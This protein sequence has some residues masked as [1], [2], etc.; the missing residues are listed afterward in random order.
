M[1]Q[2]LRS[3]STIA[4]YTASGS[5]T[6]SANGFSV[7]G[8]DGNEFNFT[9]DSY[10]TWLWKANGAGVSNTDGTITST[11]SVNTT[12]GFSIVTYTGTGANATV[13]HGLGVAPKMVIV[14]NRNVADRGWVVWH[15]GLSAASKVLILNSTAAEDT[16]TA[17]FQATIPTSSV[18]Y[19]GTDSWTNNSSDTYV[20]YAFA[21]V[22]GYSAFGSYTGNGSADGPMIFTG[23]RPRFILI[24]RS[25]DTDDWFMYDTAR[26][27]YNPMNFVLSPNSSAADTATTN[28]DDLSNGFKLR[29]TSGGTNG[30]GSTYIYM[31]FAENP[32]KYSNAR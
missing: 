2:T 7:S 17:A 1:V 13:G 32:F 9:G 14:K 24:K 23:F 3:N 11:V 22:A 15:T 30:S 28:P 8:T 26:S 27:P 5:L 20:M 31:A 4:E 25:S 16:A 6:T 18:V 12:S 10:V 19:L 29:S 21:P